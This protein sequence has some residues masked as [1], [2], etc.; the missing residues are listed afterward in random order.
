M[1][2]LH[3]MEINQKPFIIARPLGIDDEILEVA[4]KGGDLDQYFWAFAWPA[5]V[6]LATEFRKRPELVSGLSV[7]EIGSGLG[8]S[9]INAKIQGASKAVLVDT[10]LEPLQ[11]ALVTAQENGL[12][13]KG[14]S[15][16]GLGDDDHDAA[17]DDDDND[18][19][20]D[21]VSASLLDWEAPFMR[22]QKYDMIILGDV[23]QTPNIVKTL[24]TKIPSMLNPGGTVIIAG[25]SLDVTELNFIGALTNGGY[26]LEEVARREVSRD[27]DVQME[28]PGGN[29]V[30]LVR[31]RH[32]TPQAAAAAA[33]AAAATTAAAAASAAANNETSSSSSSNSDL[34]LAKL[35][36]ETESAEDPYDL[37]EVDIDDIDVPKDPRNIVM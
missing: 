24:Q 36:A 22:Q 29:S 34:N 23:F 30:H 16:L 17:A 19:D 8:I 10:L 6:A 28:D 11:C 25:A 5:A 12:K 32:I 2:E 35:L 21:S 15:G 4:Q 27:F 1:M 13:V 26:D 3:D 18:D 33:A 31:L 7:M 9:A 14:K 20:D 37:D